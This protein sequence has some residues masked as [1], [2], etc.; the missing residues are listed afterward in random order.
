VAV[1]V[2]HFAIMMLVMELDDLA[3]RA[4]TAEAPGG[5]VSRFARSEL[6]LHAAGRQVNV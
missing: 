4:L 5:S 3:T 2:K 6:L 1:A